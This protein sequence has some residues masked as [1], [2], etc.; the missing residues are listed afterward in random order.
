MKAFEQH[1]LTHSC[2]PDSKRHMCNSLHCQLT[3]SMLLMKTC[4]C[5]HRGVSMTY[6]TIVGKDEANACSTEMPLGHLC[7]QRVCG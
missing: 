3:C 2:K 5:V 7:R 4:G 1:T 6:A